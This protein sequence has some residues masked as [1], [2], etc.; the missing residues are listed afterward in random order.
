MGTIAYPS[1]Q[2]PLQPTQWDVAFVVYG[3]TVRR[4]WSPAGRPA[5]ICIRLHAVALTFSVS[6][7]QVAVIG[8]NAMTRAPLRPSPARDAIEGTRLYATILWYVLRGKATLP[9]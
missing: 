2:Q 1:D 5:A 4:W 8:S 3:P 6:P 7:L 9:R